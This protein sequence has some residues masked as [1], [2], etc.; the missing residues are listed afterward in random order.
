MDTPDDRP[1]TYNR[2]L[3]LFLLVLF[4]SIAAVVGYVLWADCIIGCPA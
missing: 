2:L 3:A 4:L 1:P